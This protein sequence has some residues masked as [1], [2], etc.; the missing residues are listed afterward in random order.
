[1]TARARWLDYGFLIAGVWLAWVLLFQWAGP[2][3]LSPPGAT[4]RRAGEYLAS[5]TFW[6]HAT[7]TGI[8]FFFACVVAL[9]GGLALGFVLGANRLARQVG[10]PMLSSLYSIPKITL[11]PVILLVFGLGISAKVAF[12]ALHGLFPVALFTIGALKNMSPVL[13][14][15]ARVMRLTPIATARSLLLPA[16]LPEIVTGLRIGFSATLLGTLIG[17]LFASDQGLGFILIR[18]MEA[19]KVIDIMALTLLLFAFAAL[20]NTLL[21]VVERRMHP[22]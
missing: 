22:R 15:T 5:P 21:L 17:E 12:G 8:A 11:Y 13:I 2:E 19:H 16:A 9:V 6:G 14:K 18:A 1:M 3:A 20:A 10:E 7:A 4:L